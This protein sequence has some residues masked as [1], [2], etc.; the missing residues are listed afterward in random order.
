MIK[1]KNK[2]KYEFGAYFKY[3]DLYYK[4]IKLLNEISIDRIGKNGI[5]F[6]EETNNNNNTNIQNDFSFNKNLNSPKNN[7]NSFKLESYSNKTNNSFLSSFKINN[8]NDKQYTSNHLKKYKLFPFIYSPTKQ[9]KY[10]TSKFNNNDNINNSTTKYSNTSIL[11][12]NSS[13]SIYPSIDKNKI[14]KNIIFNRS[15]LNNR[16]K[17]IYIKKK[18]SPN[19]NKKDNSWILND[20]KYFSDFFYDERKFKRKKISNSQNNKLTQRS[21]KKI[22]YKNNKNNFNTIAINHSFKIKEKLTLKLK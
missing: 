1:R 20:K 3:S 8:N 22:I 15:Y 9:I 18:N 4:L 21:E 10:F 11:N 14:N 19:Y 12:N 16:C 7:I 17:I 2:K 13:R 5:Y 6:G